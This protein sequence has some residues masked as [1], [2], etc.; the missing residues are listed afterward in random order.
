VSLEGLERSLLEQALRRAGNNQ[1]KASQ[2]L[3]ISRHTL[4]YR[5]EKHGL[6]QPGSAQH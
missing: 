3:G 1:T 4:R 2:L 6:L 5:M